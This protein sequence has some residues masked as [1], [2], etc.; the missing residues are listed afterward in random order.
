MNLTSLKDIASMCGGQLLQGRP[1]DL[2]SEVS[3]DSRS[4]RDGQLFVALKGDNFDAHDF[5]A[6]VDEKGA[7][8]IIVSD[9]N[10]ATEGVKCAIIHVRDTLTALQQLALFYRRK[11]DLFT[12]GVT[13]SNGKTSTKD[14]IVSVLSQR[15]G[16][17]G[18]AGNFN[19][20]I[21]LPLTVL[22]TDQRH[23]CGVWEMGMSHPG[24]IEILAEIAAPT[25][26]VIT[27]VG[28]AH[29]EFM[30]TR[31]AIAEE[32]GML[33]EALPQD[34]LLVLGAADD[35]TQAISGRSAAR[36]VTVGI[37]LGDIQARNLA[38]T[39]TGQRFDLVMDGE[40]T[41]VEIPVPGRHMVM[42]ALFAAA[43]GRERGLSRHDIAEGLR[44]V[45]LAGG[46]LQKKDVRGVIVI[47]DSYNANP[48][49]MR[50]ALSVLKDQPCTGKRA[51]VF[52]KMGE[53]GD[54]SEAEH[55][56]LGE[57]VGASGID[58]LVT[59]GED[60]K[61]IGDGAGGALD[62]ATFASHEEAG[63]FLRETLRPGDVML[64]KGSRSAAMEK[65]IK[66]FAD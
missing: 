37:E 60:G 1:S 30:K 6:E 29:I 8:A 35:F 18:T 34:G 4:V 36:T 15:Y 65:V 45:R 62:A 12:V 38:N 54:T 49:S 66:A 39:E 41:A 56:S 19:N 23:Q 9:L 14:F 10:A 2:V 21:G 32:K 13:G 50:A 55:R 64:V 20:H 33:A 3:T 17:N 52:G 51:A 24:E 28:R 61:V 48:D 31:E 11:L 16:V 59:V 40:T 27:N 25:T 22:K 63:A 58:L 7:A 53:L 57:A 46:R 44:G 43:V 5:L 42:N 47:D 26:G